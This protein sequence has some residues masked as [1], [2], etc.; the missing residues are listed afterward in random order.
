MNRIIISNIYL[1]DNQLTRIDFDRDIEV[2]ERVNAASNFYLE[3]LE[4]IPIA[5]R[6]SIWNLPIKNLKGLDK[7]FPY[8]FIDVEF[9]DNLYDF[10]DL[11]EYIEK[12]RLHYDVTRN[13]SKFRTTKELAK[14]LRSIS[15]IDTLIINDTYYE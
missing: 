1:V 13:E 3:T 9:C 12:F 2:R 8:R 11:P 6:M 7:D 10:N 4:G 14:Y 5:R 15:N